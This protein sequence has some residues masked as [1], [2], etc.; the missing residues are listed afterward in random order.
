MRN[1]GPKHEFEAE[2]FVRKKL[3]SKTRNR[4]PRASRI[5]FR[6]KNTK[7]EPA[8][9]ARIKF[10]VKNTKSEPARIARKKFRVNF[11]VGGVGHKS[12][13][14]RATQGRWPGQFPPI[15]SIQF[16]RIINFH[17]ISTKMKKKIY[18]YSK[19]VKTSNQSFYN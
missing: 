10:R 19:S 2:R 1:L 6:V 13:F 5:K 9:F 4:S 15:R 3:G 12:K 11:K 8:R 14:L 17:S 18:I 7:S 16:S